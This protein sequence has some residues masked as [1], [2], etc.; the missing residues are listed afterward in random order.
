VV[1]RSD[2]PGPVFV[3]CPVDLLYDEA[4]IRKWYADAG[5]KGRSVADRAL[6]FYLDRHV[7]KMFEGSDAATMQRVL[8]VAI[9]RAA[10]AA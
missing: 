3:E 7:R 8:P 1:A 5:G 10:P 6:R 2:V 9:P 4:S